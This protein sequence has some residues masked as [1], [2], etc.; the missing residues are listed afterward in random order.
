[1]FTPPLPVLQVSLSLR[2]KPDRAGETWEGPLR[3]NWSSRGVFVKAGVRSSGQRG[4][5]G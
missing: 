1:M 4:Q 2:E 5:A 3:Q